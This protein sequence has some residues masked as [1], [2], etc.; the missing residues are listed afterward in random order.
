MTSKLP[1]WYCH[2]M[3][4]ALSRLS[5]KAHLRG[6]PWR[7]LGEKTYS[8]C[9]HGGIQKLWESHAGRC[10]CRHRKAG[11]SVC[12]AY[13]QHSWG[14]TSSFDHGWLPCWGQN[15]EG[16]TSY[17]SKIG[18]VAILDSTRLAHSLNSGLR[19]LS[20]SKNWSCL[21]H[22]ARGFCPDTSS[23]GTC[24]LN[25]SSSHIS[26][27]CCCH[28]FI[29][30]IPSTYI[31]IWWN[32]VRVETWIRQRWWCCAG[33]NSFYQFFTLWLGS[34]MRLNEVAFWFTRA[35]WLAFAIF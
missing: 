26:Q 2:L 34:L 6:G 14:C 17:L 13:F 30:W 9:P 20:D 21:H 1:I 12:A 28:V 4:A 32:H 22:N 11:E 27:P 7:D 5:W 31:T 33:I 29:S 18:S 3:Q 19:Y 24:K 10:C 8:D 35:V 16:Q 25:L 15:T 23:F